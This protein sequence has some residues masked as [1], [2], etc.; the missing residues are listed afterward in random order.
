MR[1]EDWEQPKS[2]DE[3]RTR[4]KAFEH[5]FD[6]GGGRRGQEIAD[7]AYLL[8]RLDDIRREAWDWR[9]KGKRPELALT[10]IREILSADEEGS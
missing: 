1:I 4:L 8:G 10:N 7:I 3:V 6:V 5:W 2:I 9:E